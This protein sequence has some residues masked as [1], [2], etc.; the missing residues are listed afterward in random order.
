MTG[1]RPETSSTYRERNSTADRALDIL[2]MF[3]D[4]HLVISAAEVV[5]LLGVA[6]STAYRYL[7]SLVQS[8]FIEEADSRGYRLGRR[9]LELAR[10]ARRGMGLSEI[11]RPVM[12]RLA[13][14]V[15]EA[16]LLTRLAGST[17]ICLERED[18]GVRVVR[19][20]Y[21][22]GQVLP[23]NAGASA[24]ALLAWL[25]EARVEDIL[26]S[27]SLPSLTERTLTDKHAIVRRLGE[28]R[29]QGYSVSRGE[30]DQDVLGVGAPLRNQDGEV[31]AAISVAA[32]SARVPDE[33]LPDVAK[34]VCDAADEIS[35]V[36]ALLG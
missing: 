4:E 21:E 12:M 6:R 28:T 26:D 19:I 7:Q 33:R 10:I 3:D 18:A 20:S 8:Q 16:V 24:Y 32:V 14:E 27:A 35:A 36:L 11:A 22:R 9:V 23:T 31:V 2:L 17:V 5:E 34:A 25:P 13:T 15:G 29:E 1:Q 30:L